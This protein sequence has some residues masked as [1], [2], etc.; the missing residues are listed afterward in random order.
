MNDKSTLS[1]RNTYIFLTEKTYFAT[2]MNARKQEKYL[3]QEV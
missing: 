1:Y 3:K 2:I